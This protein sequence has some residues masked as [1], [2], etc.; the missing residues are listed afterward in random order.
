MLHVSLNH[1][2]K[3]IDNVRNIVPS[4][5]TLTELYDKQIK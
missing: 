1:M 3:E 4:Q 2:R 5:K